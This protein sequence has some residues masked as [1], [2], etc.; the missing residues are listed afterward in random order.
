[1]KKTFKFILLGLFLMATVSCSKAQI[2]NETQRKQISE[3]SL[4]T[5]KFKFEVID[6][7]MQGEDLKNIDIKIENLSSI[8]LLYH[9]GNN[10]DERYDIDIENGSVYVGQTS[11]QEIVKITNEEIEERIIPVLKDIQENGYSTVWNG[12]SIFARTDPPSY[13]VYIIDKDNYIYSIPYELYE[14]IPES[15]YNLKSIIKEIIKNNENN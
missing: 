5:V 15:V 10:P 11:R 8:T 6:K 9:T 7:K 14:N 3:Q 13:G 2:K 12:S 1:M 4:A